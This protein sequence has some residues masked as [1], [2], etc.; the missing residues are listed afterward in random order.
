MAAVQR[1]SL[2]MDL[3]ANPMLWIAA[4][5]CLIVSPALFATTLVTGSV[6]TAIGI[7]VRLK[8]KKTWP[9]AV[10]I[11]MMLGSVPYAIAA[12]RFLVSVQQ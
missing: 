7:P 11:G 3:V 5:L 8:A 9:L 1:R 12:L 10:G 4:V 6:V 2:A